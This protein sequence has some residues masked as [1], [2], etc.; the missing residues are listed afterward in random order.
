MVLFANYKTYVIEDDKTKSKKAQGG[1]RVMY[2]THNPCWDAK[3]RA[4][5]EDCV[6]FEYEQIK[7]VIEP[8]AKAAAPAPKKTEKKPAEKKPEPK[9]EP[10]AEAPKQEEEPDYIKELRTLMAKDDISEERVAAACASKGKCF[11]GA[12]LSE[13]DPDFVKENIIAKWAGF[14]KYAKKI[15]LTKDYIPFN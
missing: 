1:K 11:T 15:D 3:N 6:P 13:I 2:T 9:Q 14:A 7:K 4:G 5:L 10:K 8:E 12:K